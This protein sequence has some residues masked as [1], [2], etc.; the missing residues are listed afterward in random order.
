M[1]GR[2]S[3]AGNSCSCQIVAGNGVVI[4]GTGNAS[5][6]YQISIAPQQSNIDHGSAGAL[7][8]SGVNGY[9]SILVNLN[10]NAT[11]VVLPA[12]G[13]RIDILFVQGGS[14]NN[15]V[16]WPAVVKFPGGTDP[17]ITTGV[18]ATDWVT[19]IQAGGQWAGVKTGANLS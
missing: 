14:G 6:P 17:V 4:T 11:S 7:D 2:C 12:S 13:A 10:A 16:T 5:A 15:T 9:G 3:C 8:L 18:G 1:P 19:L